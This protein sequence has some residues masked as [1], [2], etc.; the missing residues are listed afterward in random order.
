MA[1]KGNKSAAGPE[2]IRV[3]EREVLLSVALVVMEGE[4]AVLTIPQ[5]GL[6]YTIKFVNI[7]ESTDRNSIATKYINDSSGEVHFKNWDSSTGTAT[8]RPFLIAEGPDTKISLAC[9]VRKIGTT[10]D[11]VLQFMRGTV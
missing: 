6:V 11:M 1:E 10:Y 4:E 9:T 3:G 7:P 5:V 2:L 8:V